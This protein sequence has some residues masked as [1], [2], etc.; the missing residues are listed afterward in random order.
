MFLG[1]AWGG[2]AATSEGGAHEGDICL[3][4]CGV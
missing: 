1:K 4:V 3:L 2:V